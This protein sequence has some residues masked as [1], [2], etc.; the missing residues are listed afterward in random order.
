MIRRKKAMRGFVKLAVV[1]VAMA[2][3][4]PIASAY[5]YWIY[6]AGRSGPFTPIPAKF[7]LNSLPNQSIPYLIS[8]SGPA[9]MVPGDTFTALISQIRAAADVWNGVS[10]SAAKLSFGGLSP[11]SQPDS[12]PEVDVVFD[13]NMAPGL[14]ALTRLNT[15][16]DVSG[17]L[18]RGAQFI[19]VLSARVQ[20][21]ND[22]TSV[23]P[24][25][26]S[27]SD[28]FFLTIVHEFGHALGLQH[29]LTS[30]VMSTEVTRATTK[31][32]PLAA[33]DIAGLSLLYPAN[34]FPANTGSITGTVTLKG[35]PVNMASVVALSTSGTAVSAIT[36]PDGSYRIDGIPAG[37]SYYV[38]AHPLPPAAS[39]SGE[40]YPDNIVPPQDPNGGQFPANIGFG[41]QFFGGATD[42]QQTSPITVDPG[43]S[44]DGIN[45]NVSSRPNGPAISGVVAWSYLA[46][47]GTAAYGTIP[48]TPVGT[49]PLQSGSAYFIYLAGNGIA[50]NNKVAPGLSV[51]VI[52]GTAQVTQTPSVLQVANGFT[53]LYIAVAAA[54]DIRTNTPTALAMTLNGDLYVLPAAFSVVPAPPPSITSVTGFTD[55]NGNTTATI[56]GS[57]LSASTKI[58]F[59]GAQASTVQQ[60]QDGSL[61]VT[62]PPAS[63]GYQASVEALA[64]DS[65]TSAQLSP[66][67]PTFTY[68]GPSS[69]TS[70]V[71]PQSLAAGTDSLVEITGFNTNFADGQTVVGFGSSDIV[72]KQ[73]WVVSPGL[74]RM[75]VSV[76]PA[77]AVTQSTVSV[78]SGLQ[79]AT[80]NAAFGVTAADSSV[81]S[82]RT[83]ILNQ[84]TNLP[85]VPTG[86]TVVINTAGLPFTATLKGWT[87]M[88]GNQSVHFSIGDR[89]Q[90]VAQVPDGLLTGP[91]L[92]QLTSASGVPT[93][94]VLVQIDPPSPVISSST[95]TTA[96]AASTAPGAAVFHAGDTISLTVQGLADALGNFPA[97]SS[98]VVT[99]AG[100]GSTSNVT[101]NSLTPIGGLGYPCLLQITLPSTLTPGPQ[102]ITLRL[103]TRVSTP[104]SITVQ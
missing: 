53:Y 30:S 8:S 93:P 35:S 4:S 29:T 91:T 41:T 17:T 63:N 86:G 47:G 76:S 19:P 83:P 101:P 21:H 36:N 40:A 32:V 73:L 72:V 95:S 58:L 6:F 87:L 20:L 31:A 81:I 13:D 66:A 51:S 92:V 77:A 1:A 71:N 62:A 82:L 11:M 9:V 90:I 80:L 28:G 22:L 70:T 74:L 44:T 42:W 75:N 98:I 94:P 65:Q 39:A 78:A 84:A 54:K 102:T 5:Y 10:T 34:G 26:A 104:F 46:A 89:G 57:N 69:P 79:V 103:G 61:T 27:H 2:I 18:A 33:D 88:I 45:F 38:Y 64:P 43:K 15:V 97:A 50:V 49:G 100:N 96:G 7:D 12:S 60:N 16:Q 3:L 48:G 56:T 14:L 23:Q 68:S 24:Q 85:G 37:Q 59:D 52:G 67:L 55:G 99:I 25:Q